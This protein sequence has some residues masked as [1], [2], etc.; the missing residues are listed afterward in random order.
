MS[1]KRNDSFV[2]LLAAGLFFVSV[3][4]ANAAP[5][6]PNSCYFVFLNKGAGRSKLADMSKEDTAKMQAEHVGN[7]GELGKQG[8]GLAAGPLGDDGFIR[9]IVVLKVAT[10]AEVKDCFRPDPFVQNDILAVEAYPWLVETTKFHKPDEPFK[11]VKHTLVVIKSGKD[12]H[13]A[14]GKPKPDALFKV[15][16]S[17][18]ALSKSGEL[19]AGGPLVGAKGMLGILLFVSPDSEKLQAELEQELAVKV[20][21]V[22]LEFHPQFLGAGVLAGTTEPATKTAR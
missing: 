14:P 8:R 17:L 11:I 21:R 18:R 15:L 4:A 20:G 13:P 9:G 5:S 7:L 1:R 3:G 6:P 10:P 2:P 16:P 19:A 22:T 12:F